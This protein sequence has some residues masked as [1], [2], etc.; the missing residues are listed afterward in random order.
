MSSAHAPQPAS[1]PRKNPLRVAW[2]RS[3]TSKKTKRPYQ[4][5]TVTAY[6]DAARA[7]HRWMTA[8]KIDADFTACDTA[9]LNRFFADY[10]ASHTQGG[11]NTQQRTLSHLFRWLEAAHGIPTTYV[12]SLNR[13]RR[14]RLGRPRSARSSSR[15]CSP[16]LAAAGRAALKTCVTTP[17]SGSSPKA[18][19]SPSYPR[20]R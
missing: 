2:L 6:C 20:Y 11:T 5:Q 4:E 19:G 1:A 16:S 18:R 3:Q 14:T 8:Q 15:T 13:S 17:S 7:L 12:A 9:T 10:R